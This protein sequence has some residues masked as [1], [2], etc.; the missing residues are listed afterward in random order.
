[1]IKNGFTL[2]ELI[3]VIVIL[4]ILAAT[5][6]P[7][8]VDLEADAKTAA[9][10]GIKASME[11]AAALVY[12]KSI[13]KGNHTEEDLFPIVPTP[14]S[15]NIGDGIDGGEL[16]INFGY[17]Q[18]YEDDW[19]RLIGIDDNLYD[20]KRT[21]DGKTLMIYPKEDAAPTD[22]NS[23]CITYYIQSDEAYAK[24]RIEINPC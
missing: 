4:G 17:P 1:M 21:T 16:I 18:A 9:L 10:E 14:P 13:V 24:P 15:V 7:K 2:I 19:I 8:Y 11:G 22:A 5:A 12:G 20:F 6:V 3:V 23:Q